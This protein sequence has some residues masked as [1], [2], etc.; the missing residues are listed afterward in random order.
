MN[1]LGKTCAAALAFIFIAEPVWACASRED[2][3]ALETANV[4]QRLMVAALTCHDVN[5]YNRFV[6]T[7]RRDLQ[8]SDAVLMAFFRKGPSGTAGYHAYKTRLAN[9]SALES[10]RNDDFCRDAHTAFRT[11]L[12][13]DRDTLA[14]A[15][16][17]LPQTDTGFDS[18]YRREARDDRSR[19]REDNDA[20]DAPPAKDWRW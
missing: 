16:A 1:R 4:Q 5:S 14:E 9:T 2:E 20:D 6:M 7:F 12:Y 8:D 15:L 17:R 18:C 19:G 11:V 10:V 3:F 13:D